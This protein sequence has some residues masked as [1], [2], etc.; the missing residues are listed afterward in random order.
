M[1]GATVICYARVLHQAVSPKVIKEVRVAI[2][3]SPNVGKSSLTN[4]LIRNDVCAV[5]KVIDTTRQNWVTKLKEGE[6][7]LTLVDSPGLIGIAHAKKVINTHSESKIM[8][9]PEKAFRSANHVLVVCD[10]TSPGQYIHHRVLHLLHRNS[11]IPSSLVINKTDLVRQKTKLLELANVLTCGY[12]GGQPTQLKKVKL[13][14]LQKAAGNDNFTINPLANFMEGK[15]DEW[16]EN[17]NKVINKAT[18]KCP[19]QESKKVFQTETGWPHF[20]SVFFISCENG[21][22]V[23]Q[24]RSFLKT[25]A[26]GLNHVVEE[27]ERPFKQSPYIIMVEHTRAAFLNTVP[28]D[29]AY[30]LRL[31]IADFENVGDEI[32][33]IMDVICEKERWANLVNKVLRTETKKLEAKFSKLFQCNVNLQ[34]QLKYHG[35]LVVSEE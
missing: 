23:D 1:R 9:D 5:S 18:H 12:V 19:W 20:N 3:G 25:Q 7:Q 15:S 2:I 16:K 17:Y 6:V 8:V 21:Q 24:L 32:N 33:V 34:I 4:Q 30:K 35:K 11:H 13:G 26:E 22:G 10:A 29:I 28:A 14:G 31:K 27:D